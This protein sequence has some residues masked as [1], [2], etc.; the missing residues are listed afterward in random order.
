MSGIICW[1]ND[2]DFVDSFFVTFSSGL[3]FDR[4]FFWF[5]VQIYLGL[6]AC[7]VRWLRFLVGDPILNPSLAIT[8]FRG[9]LR[10]NPKYSGF[11]RGSF[12]HTMLPGWVVS[13]SGYTAC[14]AWTTRAVNSDRWTCCAPFCFLFFGEVKWVTLHQKILK[15]RKIFDRHF[16]LGRVQKKP[17]GFNFVMSNSCA[18]RPKLQW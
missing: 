10:Y 18:M 16:F 11:F 14:V 7:P 1:N 2:N 3:L 13:P 9:F 15:W 5:I 12:Q 8:G 17:N 4:G 6:S